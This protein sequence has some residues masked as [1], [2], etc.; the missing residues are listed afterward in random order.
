M[1]LIELLE[2]LE[3]RKLR[4]FRSNNRAPRQKYDQLETIQLVLRHIEGKSKGKGGTKLAQERKKIFCL[5][6]PT[7]KKELSFE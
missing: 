1:K 7:T 5:F 4:Q 2:V 6:F 3:N